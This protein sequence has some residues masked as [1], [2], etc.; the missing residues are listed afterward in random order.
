MSGKTHGGHHLQ[1]TLLALQAIVPKVSAQEHLHHLVRAFQKNF[2]I[3]L[4][5]D[6]SASMVLAV[7]EADVFWSQDVCIRILSQ[8]GLT[9][10]GQMWKH[11]SGTWS[12]TPIG[13]CTLGIRDNLFS[14]AFF[15]DTSMVDRSQF[16]CFGCDCLVHPSSGFGGWCCKR[17]HQAP[18]HL[19]HL[20]RPELETFT[21]TSTS[22]EP[23]V[24]RHL[25]E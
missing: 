11:T 3:D 23:L 24:A 2:H 16:Q 4:D 10:I 7:A 8:N 22:V 19:R 14:G 6:G 18:S 9:A 1:E 15:Q 25:L 21:L 13:T 12:A 5:I 17:C 20:V